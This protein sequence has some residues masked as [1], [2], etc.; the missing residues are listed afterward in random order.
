MRL[1]PGTN[2]RRLVICASVDFRF[3]APNTRTLTYLVPTSDS[4]FGLEGNNDVY[5]IRIRIRIYS[6]IL[7]VRFAKYLSFSK[8]H[9]PR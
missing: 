9:V 7:A 5:S 1:A 4:Q 6:Q 2:S 3:S 8:A